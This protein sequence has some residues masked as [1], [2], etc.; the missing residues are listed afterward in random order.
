MNSGNT[1]IK[2]LWVRV[3]TSIV[4]LGIV[5]SIFDVWDVLGLEW[6]IIFFLGI[7]LVIMFR[8]AIYYHH[9]SV[10]FKGKEYE[11]EDIKKEATKILEKTNESLYYYGGSGFIGDHVGWKTEFR[12]KL[13]EP[14]IEIVRLMDLRST[15][16]IEKLLEG[17]EISKEKIQDEIRKYKNWIDIHAMYLEL[18]ISRNYFIHLDTAPIWKYGIN[19]IVFDEKHIII[20]FFTE[21]ATKLEE[22]DQRGAI[23]LRDRPDIASALVQ[24]I[25]KIV[26]ILGAKGLSAEELRNKINV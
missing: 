9:F 23:I 19:Y 25:D 6:T 16:E 5:A 10:Q 14:S 20:V 7:L 26:N 24:S 22:N 8:L 18:A 21:L 17:K 2:N 1:L 12:A 4:M 15:S 3:V 11:Q 13:K